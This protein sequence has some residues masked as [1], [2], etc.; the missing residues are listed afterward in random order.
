MS[1]VSVPSM[2][3]TARRRAT[4]SIFP[5]AKPH[6]CRTLIQP[7]YGRTAPR[8]GQPFAGNGPAPVNGWPADAGSLAVVAGVAGCVVGVGTDGVR[9]AGTGW[10]AVVATPAP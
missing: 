4:S 9:G 7:I 10:P 1:T 3:V 2:P 8:M 6:D 5:D